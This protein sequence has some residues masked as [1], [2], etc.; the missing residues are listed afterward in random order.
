MR[1]SPSHA[2]I[3][4]LQRDD[5]TMKLL[6]TRYK[7]V[8]II[9]IVASL[10]G[11][12]M[13]PVSAMAAFSPSGDTAG[14][15]A[16]HHAF[17]STQQAARLQSVLANLTRQGVDV[18][19]AQADISAGNMTAAMQ[20]LMA[21]HKDHPDT[22]T[23]GLRQHA[24]NTT[25][26]AARIQTTL[27]TLNQKGVDVSQAMA[28]LTAGNITGAMK[29][30]KTI[31]KDNPGLLAN[32]T[33]QVARLQTGITNLARQGVDVSAVQA[34][35]AS[36]NT[37]AAMKWMT[38]YHQAHPVKSSNGTTA[39]HSGNSTVNQKGSSLPSHSLRSGNQSAS[40]RGTSGHSTAGSTTGV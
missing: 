38:A 12:I 6:K 37:D 25:A 27:A 23:N 39:W 2:R 31:Q 22:V 19:T 21:Y 15:I 7:A 36:G 34:D 26:Q 24:M 14:T 5:I 13:S 16:D 10:I 20:W 40:H 32:S 1:V 28:D 18:S 9:T 11:L 33:Q 4:N 35:I 29:D 17:N 30:L 8:A 3:R